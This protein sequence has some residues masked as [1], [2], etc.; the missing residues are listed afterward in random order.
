MQTC[1]GRVN[2]AVSYRLRVFSLKVMK[3]KCISVISF[4]I[5]SECVRI[6]APSQ[7]FVSFTGN[8]TTYGSNATFSCKPGYT[9]SHTDTLACTAAGDWNGTPPTCDIKSI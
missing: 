6:D 8:A 1:N 7:G 5:I 4:C 3:M 9:L 2:T